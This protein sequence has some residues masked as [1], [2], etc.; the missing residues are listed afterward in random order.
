MIKKS[1][2]DSCVV[3]KGGRSFAP[4]TAI[5][6]YEPVIVSDNGDTIFMVTYLTRNDLIESIC[7]T[8]GRYRYTFPVH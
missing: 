5:F 7:D 4:L 1:E 2:D 6:R 3:R 8:T